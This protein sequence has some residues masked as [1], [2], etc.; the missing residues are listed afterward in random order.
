MLMLTHLAAA[1]IVI[2]AIARRLAG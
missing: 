2:P 1:A